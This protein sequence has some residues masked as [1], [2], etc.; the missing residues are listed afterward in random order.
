MDAKH[1]LYLGSSEIL[2]EELSKFRLYLGSSGILWEELS[3]SR[4][5]LGSSEILWEE[6][7]NSRP[8][9][10]DDCFRGDYHSQHFVVAMSMESNGWKIYTDFGSWSA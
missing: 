5:Y 9:I 4:L 2:W 1:Q 3:K 6:L 10:S 8:G 7:S